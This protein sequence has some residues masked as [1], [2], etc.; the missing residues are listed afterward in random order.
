MPQSV[1]VMVE[2]V[3]R[4]SRRIG[5]FERPGVMRWVELGNVEERGR[6]GGKW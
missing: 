6:G 3:E 1:I 5:G 2:N 4:I